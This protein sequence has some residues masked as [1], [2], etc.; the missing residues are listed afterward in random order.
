MMISNTTDFTNPSTFIL[1]GIPGLEMTQVWISIPF[2]TMYAIAILGNFTILFIVKM[3]PSLHVPMYHF[4]CM[5]AVTD[6]VLSTSTLPKMLSIFWFNSREINFSACL[7]QLYFIHCFSVM[8]SGIFVAMALDRYVAICDPLRHS[9]ILTNPVVAKIGLAVVLRGGMLVLP[10][11]FLA[12]QWPYCRTNIIPHT[13]CE[14]IA[15]VKLACTDIRISSY[16]GLFVAF[17]V[18][19]LDVFFIAVSYIQILRA[20]FSLPT[21]DSRLKTFGTCSSHLCVI[22]I[23][24]IPSLFSFLMH[25][26]G[27]NL[28]LHFHILIANVYLLL[29]PMLNP[30]IYG[31]RTKQIR[32]RL[33][34]LFS[35]KGT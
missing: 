20:I 6:L 33:L 25:R 3:E 22:L 4:L 9:T 8:E 24:Y 34:Q 18:T 2:C 26:F 19:G 35:H 17:L 14:H 31:V 13:Y 28:A 21:K 23:F 7:T 10:Y 30:I 5:L 16:Y 32:N 27:H 29:P 12:R 1:L 15:V 11:P